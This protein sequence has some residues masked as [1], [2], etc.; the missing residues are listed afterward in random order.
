MTVEGLPEGAG[1][2]VINETNNSA[3]G[4]LRWTPG[5]TEIGRSYSINV[6]AS[7]GQLTDVKS[8]LV[9]VV[10]A[11]QL[12]AVNA[13]DFR[14]G[15]MAADSIGAAFGTDLAVRTEF[16]R[17]LPLPLSIAE[18]TVTINGIPAPLLFV[19]PTQI[20][21]VVPST[22]DLGA[23]TIVVSN[24]LG[25]YAVGRIEIVT[26]STAIFTADA[27]GVGD[28][29]ALATAD[30]INY[31]PPPFNVLV[32]GKPNILVLYGTGLRGANT[33]NPGD[34]N[35]VAESVSITIDG[36]PARVLYAGA[37]GGFSGLD[38]INV[39]IPATLAG[40]GLRR[41]EVMVTVNGVTANRVTIQIE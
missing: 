39:E 18:T 25:A 31:Q 32:N 38:Q 24:P 9:R 19:S 26:D 10:S 29:A 7:D 33:T 1:F 27:T 17:S 28:A 5:E 3:R 6:T 16:A 11:S 40:Q 34:D 4:L 12:T 37:Q 2:E 41:V 36:K 23:A 14:P 30:G 13:A 8:V 22:L 21:F 35:G 15:P 20:N